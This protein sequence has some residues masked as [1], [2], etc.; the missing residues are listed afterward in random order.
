MQKGLSLSGSMIYQ[1][2]EWKTYTEEVESTNVAYIRK[3]SSWGNNMYCYVYSKDDENVTNGSW[4]GAAMTCV[5]GDL[6]KYEVPESISNPLVI[7]TDGTNQYPGAMEPG[8]SL[9]GSMIY[10]NGQWGQYAE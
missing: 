8:L 4:P 10:E 3:D 6:Y 1:D 7:F 9:S 5:S 2:G